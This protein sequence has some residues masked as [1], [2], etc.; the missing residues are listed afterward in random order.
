VY[1]NLGVYRNVPHRRNHAQTYSSAVMSQLDPRKDVALN[2]NQVLR[3]PETARAAVG[4][5]IHG[6]QTATAH[7]KVRA[8]AGAGG[9][10]CNS[11][12]RDGNLQDLFLDRDSVGYVIDE[13]IFVGSCCCELC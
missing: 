7:I 5:L 13:D 11:K 2:C 6:I 3:Y 10:P 9:V 8:C 4:K 1:I 12:I